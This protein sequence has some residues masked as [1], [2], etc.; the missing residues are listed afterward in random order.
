M[1]SFLLLPSLLASASALANPSVT[2]PR[3]T[4]S[5]TVTTEINASQ[6]VM[7]S[8]SSIAPDLSIGADDN[9]TISLVHSS[10][11]T[12]G[13]RGSAGLGFCVAD[14]CLYTYNNVGLEATHA[15]TRG[16][17]ASGVTVGL[18]ANNIYQR[19]VS[20][21]VGGRIRATLGDVTLASNPS[22]FIA[23]SHRDGAD[24][25]RHRLF[26]PISA[27]YRL[28]PAVSL[29]IATG[30]KAAL[31]DVVGS[32]EIAA[33]ALCHYT[34]SPTWSAGASWVHGKIVG[35]DMALPAGASGVDYRA[36]QLWLTLTR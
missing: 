18:Y 17:F 15:A 16:R 19:W 30:F 25:N 6:D 3:G 23:L 13:F 35:G 34:F 26:L 22:V 12:T 8:P 7:G 36:L 9:L 24:M 4:V 14:E 27:M 1:R 21:K 11:A 5:A 10:F 20:G 29:G 28:A 33:G 31:D 32:Y 2:L